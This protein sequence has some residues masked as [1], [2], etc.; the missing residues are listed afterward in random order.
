MIH[1]IHQFSAEKASPWETV[2][3]PRQS[4]N[5]GNEIR[6]SGFG[7]WRGFAIGLPISLAIWLGVAVALVQIL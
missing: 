1:Q 3:L 7:L 4:R 2:L 6:E 5:H